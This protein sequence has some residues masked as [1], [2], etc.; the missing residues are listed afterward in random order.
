MSS[1]TDRTPF[2]TVTRDEA[3]VDTLLHEVAGNTDLPDLSERIL[4]SH[5]AGDGEDAADR[6]FAAAT[7]AEDQTWRR[8]LAAALV[9]LGL[10]VVTA[11]A[12]FREPQQPDRPADESQLQDPETAFVRSIDALRALLP[13]VERIS[14][15]VLRYPDANLPEIDLSAAPPL[16]QDHAEAVRDLTQALGQ[17]LRDEPPAGWKWPHRI[18]LHLEDGRAVTLAVNP[19]E[20]GPRA[21]VDVLGLE[22]GLRASPAASR[23]LRDLVARAERTA[24]R[25][26]GVVIERDDL[27]PTN[28][29]PRLTENLRLYGIANAD[30]ALLERFN[31]TRRIDMSGLAQ[32]LNTKGLVKF[33]HCNPLRESLKE[34]V[35]DGCAIADDDMTTLTPFIRLQRLSMRGV[36]GFTGQGWRAYIVSSLY[37]DGPFDVDLSEVDSLTDAGIARMMQWPPTVLALANSEGGISDVGWAS[38]MTAKSLT[39]LDLSG[40]RIDVD[41][42]KDLAALP[43]LERLAL[44]RCAL[45][46]QTLAALAAGCP[47]LTHLDLRDNGELTTRDLMQLASIETLTQVDVRDCDKIGFAGAEAFAKAREDCEVLR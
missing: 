35:L 34:L 38:L 40:W 9:L 44:R 17:D 7:Q 6:V 39:A 28:G 18:Y 36:K 22:R 15:R 46:R 24:R 43:K 25:Q 45:D 23:E 32:T 19:Y 11:I 5:L 42:A 30:L 41:R 47:S 27:L 21:L 33:M 37:R 14:V 12:V 1:P 2:E 10:G 26:L 16:R 13:Q 29:L 8:W 4:A 3:L 31:A 20:K